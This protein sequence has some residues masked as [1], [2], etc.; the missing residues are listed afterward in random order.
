MWSGFFFLLFIVDDADSVRFPMFSWLLLLTRCCARHTST[1]TYCTG[2]AAAKFRMR[3]RLQAAQAKVKIQSTL[4][5]PRWRTFR[6]SPIV[7]NQPKHSS[8]RF[9]FLWLTAYPR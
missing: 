1:L 7:F 2:T 6:I 4:Q 9:L 3:T 8:I 5:T